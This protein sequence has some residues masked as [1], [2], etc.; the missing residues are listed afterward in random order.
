PS[1]DDDGGKP[2]LQVCQ[3]R[4]L[5]CPRELQRHEEIACL[6]HA[7]DE[8][9][10][11]ANQRRLSRA[12]GERHVVEAVAI[13]RV[14]YRDGSAEARSAI[15]AEVA[16]AGEVQMEHVEERLVPAHGDAVLGDAA[17]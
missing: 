11:Q 4:L 12:R 3:R 8:V 5:E 6:A 1:A 7:A 15:E 2:Y 17:E 14:L 10:L 9:V 13:E 16:P